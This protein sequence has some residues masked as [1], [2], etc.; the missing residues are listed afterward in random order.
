MVLVAQA[1]CVLWH[2]EAAFFQRLDVI[3]LCREHH[4]AELLAAHAQRIALE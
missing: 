4:Q 1:L 3:A 2:I